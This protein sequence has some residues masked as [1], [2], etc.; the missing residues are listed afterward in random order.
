M[1]RRVARRVL[2]VVLQGVA[3]GK[4]MAYVALKA[5]TVPLGR[6]ASFSG[7][8]ASLSAAFALA[9]AVAAWTFDPVAWAPDSAA[10]R[11]VGTSSFDDRFPVAS[12]PD[13]FAARIAPDFVFRSLYSELESE[14][15]RA[16]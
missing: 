9:S 10:P 16:K 1:M 7:T 5:G 6:G 13:S 11:D 4:W 12:A 8:I 14:F 3:P 2:L 15:K